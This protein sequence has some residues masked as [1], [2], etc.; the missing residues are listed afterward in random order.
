M[1]WLIKFILY[2]HVCSWKVIS[3]KRLKWSNDFGE[4][5]A[6]ERFILQCEKCGNIKKVDGK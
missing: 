1:F 6:C 2:G 3:Q 5:G 4:H